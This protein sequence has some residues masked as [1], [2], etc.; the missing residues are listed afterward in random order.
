MDVR[1]EALEAALTLPAAPTYCLMQSLTVGRGS[2][3]VNGFDRV[4]R[5]GRHQKLCRLGMNTKSF[6]RRLLGVLHVLFLR[7]SN[8]PDDI[9]PSRLHMRFLQQA[10]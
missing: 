2:V 9:G 5:G 8:M 10:F 6:Q 7:R 4:A 3:R 1:G